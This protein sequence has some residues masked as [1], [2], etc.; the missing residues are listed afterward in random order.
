MFD[1]RFVDPIEHLRFHRPELERTNFFLFAGEQSDPDEPLSILPVEQFAGVPEFYLL[2]VVNVNA[3]PVVIVPEPPPENGQLDADLQFDLTIDGQ[4]SLGGVVP[5][6]G[7]HGTAD[8]T[9]IN[10]LIA[11]INRALAAAFADAEI[12]PHLKGSVYAEEFDGQIAFRMTHDGTLEANLFGGGFNFESLRSEKIELFAAMGEYSVRITLSPN[13]T[14][15]VPAADADVTVRSNNPA[16]QPTVIPLGDIDGNQGGDF[17]AFLRDSVGSERDDL[18]LVDPDDYPPTHPADR[19]DP[20]FA[21][22]Y[23]DGSA[24]TVSGDASPTLRLPAPVRF[25]SL[26]GSQSV[27]ATPGDYDGDGIHDVAVSVSTHQPGNANSPFVSAGVYELFGGDRD[28]SGPIDVTH[29]ADVTITGFTDRVS[30]DNAGD[31]NGDGID[32]LLI[33]DRDQVFVFHGRSAT[34]WEASVNQPLLRADFS[35][36]GEADPDGFA[37]SVPATGETRKWQVTNRR[38]DNPNH[39]GPHSLYF[40][41]EETGNYAGDAVSGQA[42][43]PA[44][45]LSGLSEA[46]LS[47]RYFL[48]TEAIADPSVSLSDLDNARLLISTTGP[49]GPFEALEPAEIV[50]RVLTESSG[51][52]EIEPGPLDDPSFGWQEAV[53]SLNA[54]LGQTVHLRFE[55]TADDDNN[56][57]EGWYID[58]V[59]VTGSRLTSSDAS[60]QLPFLNS[61]DF[62]AASLDESSIHVAGLGDFAGDELDDFAQFTFVFSENS[63]RQGPRIHIYHGG[64]PAGSGPQTTILLPS[65]FTNVFANPELRTAPD[66]LQSAGD[67]TGDGFAD[68]LLNGPVQSYVIPGGLSPN[69]DPIPLSDL[70]PLTTEG[71]FVALGQIESEAPAALGAIVMETTDALSEDGREVSHQVAHV[72]SSDQLPDSGPIGMPDL[73]F[74]PAHPDYSMEELRRLTFAAVHQPGGN[75]V[76]LL[77]A[78]PIGG[79][80][81]VFAN[82]ELG[83]SNGSGSTADSET[84]QQPRERFQFELAASWEGP[85]EPDPPGLNVFANSSSTSIQDAFV[86]NGSLPNQ[87]LGT[88]QT[89]GDINGDGIDDVMFAGENEAYVF[90]GPLEIEGAFDIANRAN[91]LIVLATLGRPAER[92]GDIDGDGIHDLVFV[93]S[94][95]TVANNFRETYDVSLNVIWGRQNWNRELDAAA[96]DRSLSLTEEV[97]F[98]LDF[99]RRDGQPFTVHVLQWNEDEHGD[100]L[101]VSRGHTKSFEESFQAYLISGRQVADAGATA[102]VGDDSDLDFLSRV[103]ADPAF[104]DVVKREFF[105]PHPFGYNT[106]QNTNVKAR[107]VGDANGDGLEDVLFVDSGFAVD[108][109]APDLGRAYLLTGRPTMEMPSSGI[110]TL[111]EDTD[112]LLQ[113]VDLGESAAAVGD[114]NQDGY[115][116]FAIEQDKIEGGFSRGSVFVFFSSG[117]SAGS[118]PLTASEEADVSLHR[119]ELDEL[120][121]DYVLDAPLS[122]A[123]GDFNGDGHPDLAIGEPSRILTTQDSQNSEERIILDRNERGRVHVF[124]SILEQGPDLTLADAEMVLNGSRQFDRLGTLQIGANLDLNQDGLDDLLIGASGADVFKGGTRNKAGKV[125]L[126]QGDFAQRPLPEPGTAQVLVNRTISGSGD[127]LVQEND[128]QPFLHTD[129]LPPGDESEKW[130]QFSTLGD[131]Q[132]GDQLQISPQPRPAETHS[133]PVTA[134]VL[135]DVSGEHQPIFGSTSLEVGGTESKITVLE[136]D[137]SPWISLMDDPSAVEAALLPLDFQVTGS[138]NVPLVESVLLEEGDAVVT[139]ADANALAQSTKNLTLSPDAGGAGRVTLDLT[140]AVR[141]AL[142]A[143]K[144]RLTVRLELADTET[145]IKFTPPEAELE[146]QVTV[147]ESRGVKADLLSSTGGLLAEE[148]S[149][150]P[151]FCMRARRRKSSAHSAGRDRGRTS[152]GR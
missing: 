9:N 108:P 29:D 115:D 42:T 1:I 58:D 76:D 36:D 72:Y 71:R 59:K 141:T 11:D 19:I 17:I 139:A 149:I 12:P 78:D 57:F 84:S 147:A 109:R 77:L 27:F 18:G 50:N 89:I 47:F 2:H 83:I 99:T 14:I 70:E 75:L 146:F 48:E 120:D 134:G 144:T 23:L 90:F 74:E 15:D 63:D 119:L 150:L 91:L 60:A 123:A 98:D 87:H 128:G 103:E 7:L 88:S 133:L 3:Y 22:I 82:R 114:L 52:T 132:P 125:Y 32:D 81:Y 124:P 73:V 68:L 39:S 130:F 38:A 66:F 101:L 34:T 142:D 55:F 145:V 62:R 16:D 40:G 121:G 135:E 61:E 152:E 100:V 46:R 5:I 51:L 122:I 37:F 41:D 80:A 117:Q 85:P 25:E 31:V 10:N 105:G 53:V 148:R 13:D 102:T 49:D 106:D 45:D 107:V 137:L 143:G 56:A 54:Y 4:H 110:L 21:R 112:L 93:A 138:L 26:F 65:E 127:F 20:T 116:D 129:I 126:L 86:L 69:S 104:P 136:L 118:A 92:M 30:V 24:E 8:N 151:S 79:N 67:V 33:G 44:I 113:D 140:D 94:V 111:G 131:G 64:Q 95:Q 28:W 43:T 6:G 35:E 96:V 97:N